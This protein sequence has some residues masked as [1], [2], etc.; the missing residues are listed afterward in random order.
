MYSINSA[1]HMFRWCRLILFEVILRLADDQLPYLY[2]SHLTDA[3]I[4]C[5]LQFSEC[6][7]FHTGPPWETNPQSW[8]CKRHALPTELQGTTIMFLGDASCLHVLMLRILST[9]RQVFCFL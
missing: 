5:D 2:F 3:L 1:G 8:C 6:I 4:Q 7:H 9:G